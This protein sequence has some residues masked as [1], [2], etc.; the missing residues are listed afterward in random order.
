M[1][2]GGLECKALPPVLAIQEGMRKDGS[3]DT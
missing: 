2:K 1:L 3:M